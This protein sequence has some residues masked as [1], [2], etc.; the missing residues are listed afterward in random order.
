MRTR[1]PII[2]VFF[3][4]GLALLA[5]AQPSAGYGN[6]RI[7]VLPDTQNESQFASAM[8]TAQ[9]QWIVDNK[10]SITFVA[11]VGDVVNTCTSST[12]YNNANAA[13]D[14]LDV[15]NVPYGV[16]PGNHDQA[17]SG[18]CGST[19]LYPTYF[20]T[21][22]FSSKPYFGGS[23]DNYNHYF[24]FSAGGMEFIIIFLQYNP[25]TTQTN[26]ASGLLGLYPN[27]RGIVVTHG[28][29]NI[30]NS[31]LTLGYGGVPGETIYT[32]LSGN[33]NLFLML[34]GHMHGITDGTAWRTETRSGMNPVHIILSDYQDVSYGNGWLRILE[35]DPSADEIYVSTYSPYLGSSNNDAAGFSPLPYDMTTL[36]GDFAGNDCDADGSDLASLI[37]HPSGL[38]IATFAQNFGRT[39]CP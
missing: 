31:W 3:I 21:P 30:D 1:N 8:F 25:G 14:L 5:V 33:P 29:I 26:W 28:I 17:N 4:L 24:L 12:Q 22:R 16:S 11:H 23:L 27:H 18:V 38:N 2:R 9:T 34:C 13:M 20:G 6:F 7:I 15:D 19:S 37:A 39:A 10:G 35:F 32:S 36:Y